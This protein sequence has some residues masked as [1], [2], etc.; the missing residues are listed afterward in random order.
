MP[1]SLTEN[2]SIIAQRRSVILTKRC[3]V[4]CPLILFLQDKAFRGRPHLPRYRAPGPTH[5]HA[6]HT[7]RRL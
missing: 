2:N 4:A 7:S 5:Q 6:A 1:I 3:G